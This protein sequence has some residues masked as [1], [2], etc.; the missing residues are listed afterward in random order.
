MHTFLVIIVDL[1]NMIIFVKG[2]N[3]WKFTRR[4]AKSNLKNWNE[5]TSQLK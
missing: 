5:I 1:K 2:D 3:W 4:K